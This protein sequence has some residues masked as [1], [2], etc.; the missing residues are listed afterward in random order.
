METKVSVEAEAVAEAGT[1]PE[2]EVKV[3][4]RG[5]K[6]KV[7]FKIH[8]SQMIELMQLLLTS[9]SNLR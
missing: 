2:A 9:A 6:I 3:T 8:K 5:E 7:T 4:I 1:D